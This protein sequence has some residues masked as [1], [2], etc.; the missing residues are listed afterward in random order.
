MELWINTPG[1]YDYE[2]AIHAWIP[3]NKRSDAAVVIFPG[4]AYRGLAEHEGAGYAEFLAKN[5]ITA[6]SVDYRVYPHKFPLEL[7]DARRAVRW[8]RANADLYGIRKD[9]IAVMGSSAGG[10]LAALVSTYREQI[11]FED[12][13]DVDREDYL[14]NAQIL[15]YPVICCPAA[16]SIAHTGSYHNLLTSRDDA[17]EASVDPS[18]IADELTPP[19]FIWH[20][21][22]DGGVNVINSYRYAEKL[23]LLNIPVEMHIFPYG[24][25]GLGLAENNPHVAQWSGLLLNWLRLLEWLA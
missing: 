11:L 10:H 24:Q 14:P 18:L 22:A 5:G 20:T 15:C 2:P 12:M 1:E 3:E 8:V 13:D 19:A 23:R 6:F 9:Q 4:G 21:A 7:L 17:E 25:H 16:G